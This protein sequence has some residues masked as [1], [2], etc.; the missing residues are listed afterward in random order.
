MVGLKLPSSLWVGALVPVEK[1]KDIL[2]GIFLE[3]KQDLAALL[4]LDCSSFVSG[5]PHLPDEQLFESA[6]WSSEMVLEA[7]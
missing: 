1:L 3:E 7:E 6:L 2:L 4:F 5:F